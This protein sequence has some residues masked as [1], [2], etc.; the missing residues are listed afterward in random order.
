VSEYTLLLH[1]WTEN[2]VGLFSENISYKLNMVGLLAMHAHYCYFD[3]S[4]IN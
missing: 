2:E 3:T 1:I 4:I